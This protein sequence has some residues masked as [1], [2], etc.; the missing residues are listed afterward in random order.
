M[1]VI[2]IIRLV[3]LV[4]WVLWVLYKMFVRKPKKYKQ[5]K[6]LVKTY[7]DW[8]RKQKSIEVLE[9][10]LQN[11][12]LGL[13]EVE[14]GDVHLELACRYAKRKNYERSAEHFDEVFRLIQADERP[15]RYTPRFLTAIQ[16]YLH[17]GQRKH[18]N[19]IYKDLI[20]RETY[21]RNYRKMKKAEPWLDSATPPPVKCKW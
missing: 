2:D 17:L 12:E 20:Q 7:D 1:S 11:R 19:A 3:L 18:A 9:E 4:V 16:V 5:Y 6:A 8:Y 21:D 13:S 10:V 14:I 15:W